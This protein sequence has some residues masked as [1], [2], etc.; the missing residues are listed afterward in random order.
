M[1]RCRH[2]PRRPADHAS[3]AGPQLA[4]VVTHEMGRMEYLISLWPIP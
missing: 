2:A 3:T 4:G 1:V